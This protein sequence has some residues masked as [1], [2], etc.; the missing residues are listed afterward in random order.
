MSTPRSPSTVADGW[1]PGCRCTKPQSDRKL[2]D[3]HNHSATVLRLVA[4]SLREL[5]VG[6]NVAQSPLSAAAVPLSAD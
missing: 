6:W 1:T 4:S 2:S 5:L 3:R